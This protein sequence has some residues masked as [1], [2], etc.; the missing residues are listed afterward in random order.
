MIKSN[1]ILAEKIRRNKLSIIVGLVVII[2]I[3]IGTIL[4]IPNFLSKSNSNSYDYELR[5]NDNN[6]PGSSYYIRINTKTRALLVEVNNFCSYV[7]CESSIN[8]FGP[9]ILTN[10]EYTKIFSIIND[11]GD[12][13]FIAPILES[14][15]RNQEPFETTESGKVTTRREFANQ[16]LDS[17]IEEMH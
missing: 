14:Y 11:G 4:L 6:I 5:Y 8:D 7:D 17:V 1:K 9:V 3:A 16:W 12:I 13:N 15:A 10:E 2:A